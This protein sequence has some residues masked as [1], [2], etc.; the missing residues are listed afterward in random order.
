MRTET[1]DKIVDW[2][3]EIAQDERLPGHVRSDARHKIM[4][5]ALRMP[6]KTVEDVVV[7]KH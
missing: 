7:T 3:F 1:G 6:D 2:L 4:L 5:C